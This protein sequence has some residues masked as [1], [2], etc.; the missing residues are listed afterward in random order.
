MCC[1]LFFIIFS[2]HVSHE[3]PCV[4]MSV[5]W[6]GRDTHHIQCVL[7]AS[8]ATIPHCHSWRVDC[9]ELCAHYETRHFYLGPSSSPTTKSPPVRHLVDR[10]P[11][12]RLA[13]SSATCLGTLISMNSAYPPRDPDLV[14]MAAEIRI[15]ERSLDGGF[16]PGTIRRTPLIG[17]YYQTVDLPISSS[18]TNG[19]PPG[20]YIIKESSISPIPAHA[21]LS[22]SDFAS[23]TA[24]LY[25]PSMEQSTTVEKRKPGLTA[26]GSLALSPPLDVDRTLKKS[27]KQ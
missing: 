2:Q 27:R 12:S 13:P 4:V 8:D 22:Q 6:Y 1:T 15:E 5:R 20:R 11:P 23:P 24:L 10:P 19:L 14:R 7:P 21:V 3:Y 16:L 25:N 18:N 26:L 9:P 17:S